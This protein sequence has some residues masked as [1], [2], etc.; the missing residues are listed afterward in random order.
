M[1]VLVK[2]LDDCWERYR[3]ELKRTRREF[4]NEYVHDLRVSIRRLIAAIKIGRA[5]VHQDRFKRSRRLLKSQLDAFDALRD[6]Q[7]QLTIVEELQEDLPEIVPYRD[8]LRKQE[9]KLITRLGKAIKEFHSNGLAQQVARL[10]KALLAKD[11]PE[12]ES[13]ILSVADEAYSVVIQR[14]AAVRADHTESIHRL[15]L[16]F[17]K[18]R[19]TVEGIYPLLPGN[20]APHDLRRRLHDYQAAMGDIQDI[21]VGSQMLAAFVAKSHKELP[22][23][24]AAFDEMHASR[25][26][27]F[28][29]GMN[30]VKNFWRPAPEK[31]FPWQARKRTKSS[32]TG[33]N[34]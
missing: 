12:G 22:G 33:E 29:D 11:I 26:Q 32:E 34:S 9:K 21:E 17:K 2:R 3:A 31:K 7:V 23:S 30:D 28:M 13:V 24:M 10:R 4:A 8:H 19:Y 15:R 16:A 18:F 5:V 25:V 20:H 14:K 27:T 6:T 1:A